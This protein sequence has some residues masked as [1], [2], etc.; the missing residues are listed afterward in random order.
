MSS[1]TGTILKHLKQKH[2]ITEG[3]V[4]T[5]SRQTLITSTTLPSHRVAINDAAVVMYVVRRGDVHTLSEEDSFREYS[6]TLCPGFEPKSA[7]TIKRGILKLYFIL[8][9]MLMEYFATVPSK[10]STTFDGW[11]NP[12]LQGLYPVTLHWI[13]TSVGLLLTCLL[14]F[15]YIDPGKGAGKRIGTAICER[16][17]DFQ[18]DDKILAV[19]NDNGSDAIAAA[20]YVSSTMTASG[21]RI[22]EPRN[23]LRC[24]KHTLQLGIKSAVDV[25]EPALTRLRGLLS[26]VRVSKVRRAVFR[27]VCKGLL[28]KEFE[29]PCTD[30]RTRF[31]S[32]HI[33]I[34]QC[35]ALQP[36]L[37][38]IAK[39]AQ[40]KADLADYRLT[41]DDWLHLHHVTS[42]L[43]LPA[44]LTTFLGGDSYPTLSVAV[45]ANEKMI[46]HCRQF[47]ETC[48]RDNVMRDAIPSILDYHRK[49]EPHL[50]SDAALVSMFLDPRN[51][52]TEGPL[53]TKTKT[54]IVKLDLLTYSAL[55][56]A[57]EEPP[58][59]AD[60]D[61]DLWNDGGYS[62]EATSL[63]GIDKELSLFVATVNENMQPRQADVIS[64]WHSNRKKYR[65]L[66]AMAMDYLAIPATFIPS[67]RANSAAGRAYDG[68]ESLASPMFKAEMCCRSWLDLFRKL[69]VAVPDDLNAAFRARM[70]KLDADQQRDLADNDDVIDLLLKELE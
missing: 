20:E 65:R 66:Y 8:R 57:E 37:D 5:T 51:A 12:K 70:D 38:M 11:S 63:E 60:T 15:T 13:D 6:R 27:S 45:R 44:R 19:V 28:D 53:L 25:V 58:A 61:D 7:R 10:V 33:M 17:S 55:S 42:F 30:C 23:L 2:G 46:S 14:D 40:C 47:L 56:D 41:D 31:N 18:I 29:P 50:N 26:T 69:K 54:L 9:S 64:W 43:E 22:V 24:A 68:R 52:K 62:A 59:E 16:L 48:E 1:S 39:H 34:K 4:K 36:A 35:I 32:T 3:H 67:E 21:H 49:Y